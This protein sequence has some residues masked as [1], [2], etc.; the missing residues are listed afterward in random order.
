MDYQDTEMC[1]YFEDGS[2]TQDKENINPHETGAYSNMFHTF[3]TRM[4]TVA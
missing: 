4:G 1:N 3:M 2:D